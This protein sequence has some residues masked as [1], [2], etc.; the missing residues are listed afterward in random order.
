VQGFV[1]ALKFTL[2]IGAKTDAFCDQYA[3]DQGSDC[4]QGDCG[5]QALELYQQLIPTGPTGDIF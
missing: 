2:L 4:H 1:Q 5:A 3:D